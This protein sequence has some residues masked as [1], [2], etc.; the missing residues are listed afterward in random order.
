MTYRPLR[1]EWILPP[2]L[3]MPKRCP[4]NDIWIAANAMQHGLAVLTMDAHFQ[5]IPQILAYHVPS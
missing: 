4:T 3:P 2:L 5:K 1:A